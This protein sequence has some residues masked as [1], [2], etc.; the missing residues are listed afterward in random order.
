MPS[1]TASVLNSTR[2]SGS[3]RSINAQ[4]SPGPT[5]VLSLVG[6]ERVRRAI[7]SNSFMARDRFLCGLP[8]HQRPQKVDQIKQAVG[9]D[10]RR[11]VIGHVVKPGQQQPQES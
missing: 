10:W 3:P 11:Q 8:Y 2:S 1:T 5:T 6:S 4:S 9:E 7:N